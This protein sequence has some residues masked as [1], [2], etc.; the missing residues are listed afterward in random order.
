MD[1]GIRGYFAE[2]AR[3]ERRVAGT[4]LAV[5]LAFLGLLG[6]AVSR[7]D[8]REQI[9][10]T[11]R[12]GYEGPDRYVRRITLL[13]TEGAQ[14]GLTALGAVD[15]GARRRSGP[16][17]ERSTAGAT[18]APRRSQAPRLG[19]TGDDPGLAELRRRANLPTVQ[20]EE[21]VIARKREPQY[22]PLALEQ[23]REGDVKIQ[24]LIDTAGR[25]VEVEILSA[26][27]E[28]FGSAAAEAVW[29]FRF[30]PYRVAGEVSDVYTILRFNFRIY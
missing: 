23:G 5:G 25:V 16:S 4:T 14:P 27:E 6:I 10:R 7:E 1:H 2:R 15:P 26:S 18:R 24:A 11:A 3:F 30:H 19:D 9:N 29:Q 17:G 28:E 21:L 20:S 13:Q 12:I 22:P 8:V